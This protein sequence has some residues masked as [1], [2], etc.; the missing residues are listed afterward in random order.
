MFSP[1]EKNRRGSARILKIKF[2]NA[3][4]QGPEKTYAIGIFLVNDPEDSFFPALL[5]FSLNLQL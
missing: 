3:S 5:R 1:D 4:Q 2:L